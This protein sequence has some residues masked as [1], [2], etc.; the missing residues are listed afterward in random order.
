MPAFYLLMT[1]ALTAAAFSERP[2]VSVL[3]LA[4]IAAGIPIASRARLA[5][6]VGA[7]LAAFAILGLWTLGTDAADRGI[8]PLLGG[9]YVRAFAALA[10][11]ALLVT[12]LR[13]DRRTI[14]GQVA[15]VVDLGLS[16]LLVVLAA[17]VPAPGWRWRSPASGSS[18]RRRSPHS[19]SVRRGSPPRPPE[20]ACGL[21]VPPPFVEPSKSPAGL[22][23]TIFTDG[24]SSHPVDGARSSPGRSP[25]ARDHGHPVPW[26]SVSFGTRR[27]PES[28]RSEP[29]DL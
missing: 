4:S 10:A 16:A 5:H 18:P 15:T 14:A 25:A 1:A 23:R 12:A 20:P 7:L 21:V 22:S 28:T 3:S 26:Q 19:A 2:E 6:V 24:A 27:S 8:E 17:W 29:L 9:H 11:F 13:L